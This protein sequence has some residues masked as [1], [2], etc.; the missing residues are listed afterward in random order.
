MAEAIPLILNAKVTVEDVVLDCL[1]NEVA[2]E[3]DTET[4]EIK[5][6]CGAAEYPGTTKWTFTATFYQSFDVGGTHEALWPLVEARAP[7]TIT[8]LPHRDLPISA[9][10]PEI[11]VT[12]IPSPYAPISG[13]AGEPS[14]VEIEW[15][16]VGEPTF[17]TTPTTA[18]ATSAASG[19]A[20]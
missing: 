20:A 14:E 1:T 12:A 6:M 3:P 5:T 9:T 4:T 8:V 10:N 16:V 17:N 11:G 13:T 2:I 19:E 15:T 18:A 7:V